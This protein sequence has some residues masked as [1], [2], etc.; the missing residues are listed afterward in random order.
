MEANFNVVVA[1][2]KSK[3]DVTCV[4]ACNLCMV[5]MMRCKKAETLVF[6]ASRRA[7]YSSSRLG[8]VQGGIDCVY[9]SR[10]PAARSF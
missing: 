9:G 8:T 7:F 6:V 5:P 2:D 3:W 4:V 10:R 1:I